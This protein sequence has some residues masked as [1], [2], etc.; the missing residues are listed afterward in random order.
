MAVHYTRY[1][2]RAT[3]SYDYKTK[4][5]GYYSTK[6]AAQA[7]CDQVK[8]AY[9]LGELPDPQQIPKKSLV[10]I[11]G[12]AKTVSEWA[13]TLGVTRA[14]LYSDCKKKGKTMQEVITSRL[15]R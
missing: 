6:E 7:A 12:E 10:I 5:I 14:L 8:A 11:N 3:F 15:D 1:G 9:L 13:K 2:W 4:H